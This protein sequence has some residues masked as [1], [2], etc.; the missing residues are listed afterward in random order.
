M[1]LGQ[2]VGPLQPSC[3]SQP[4][5]PNRKEFNMQERTLMFSGVKGPAALDHGPDQ[6]EL[7]QWQRRYP[8]GGVT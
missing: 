3:E 6:P 4:T 1:T 2:A 5:N 7:T 8:G